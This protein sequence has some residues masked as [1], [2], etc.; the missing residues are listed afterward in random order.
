MAF[1]ASLLTGARRIDGRVTASQIAVASAFWHRKQGFTSDG[2]ISRTS[3]RCGVSS[4]AQALA[5]STGFDANEARWQLSKEPGDLHPA[6]L[7]LQHHMALGIATVE[8]EH[9]LVNIE[10]DRPDRF[11]LSALHLHTSR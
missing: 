4:R 5:P 7:P 11:N 10:A 8:L 3:R 2:G 1:C 6:Q 9:I